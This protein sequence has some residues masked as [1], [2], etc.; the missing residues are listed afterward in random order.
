M[1]KSDTSP[2]LGCTFRRKKRSLRPSNK[3]R[4]SSSCAQLEYLRSHK[5]SKTN[6]IM[7]FFLFLKS[8]MQFKYQLIGNASPVTTASRVVVTVLEKSRSHLFRKPISVSEPRWSICQML[9]KFYRDSGERLPNLGK[10][11]P[12]IS[13]R[14]RKLLELS[15]FGQNSD[16]F[17]AIYRGWWKNE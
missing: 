1:Y 9:V 14:F 15:E 10:I 17:M 6:P 12:N 7:L 11:L 2:L 13:P 16:K 8:A 4:S 3:M 5:R